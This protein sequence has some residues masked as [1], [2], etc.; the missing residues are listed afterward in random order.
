MYDVRGLLWYSETRAREKCNR[1]RLGRDFYF[2]LLILET[3]F[4]RNARRVSRILCSGPE[5]EHPPRVCRQYVYVCVCGAEHFHQSACC[6]RDFPNVRKLNEMDHRVV[7]PFDFTC[8]MTY[9]IENRR[10]KVNI[11]NSSDVFGDLLFGGTNR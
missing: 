5:N 4:I 8:P 9:C 2:F 3:I 7:V 6:A 11:F 10:Q 1:K